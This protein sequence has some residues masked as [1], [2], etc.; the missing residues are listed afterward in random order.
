MMTCFLLFIYICVLCLCAHYTDACTV[1][2]SCSHQV[3]TS[4][5]ISLAF[6]K[7]KTSIGLSEKKDI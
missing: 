7:G 6:H 4:G 2:C 1:L 3:N 5:K